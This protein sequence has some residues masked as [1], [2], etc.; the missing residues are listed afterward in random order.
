LKNEE[1]EVLPIEKPAKEKL[2]VKKAIAVKKSNSAA[3][4]KEERDLPKINQAKPSS[5]KSI[6]SKRKLTNSDLSA[7]T[8]VDDGLPTLNKVLAAYAKSTGPKGK[9]G[10]I[11]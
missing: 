10:D 11:N 2:L 7:S 4:V 9:I 8:A 6:S 3:A 1:K 5:K